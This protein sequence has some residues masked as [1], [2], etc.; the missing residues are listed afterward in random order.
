[1]EA[2][3][4]DIRSWC[5]SKKL[6]LNDKKAKLLHFSSQFRKSTLQPRLPIGDL[7][8]SPSPHAWNLGE[9]MNSSLCMNH[10]NSVCVW[11][12]VRDPPISGYQDHWNTCLKHPGLILSTLC[13]LDSP[14]CPQTLSIIQC[15]SKTKVQVEK[16]HFN[17]WLLHICHRLLY[18][19]IDD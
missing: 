15:V 5:F 10:V 18:N 12:S 19:L 14:M 2:R 9:V 16:R 17:L 4:A 1:M 7:V 13:C 3:I 6:A 11:K 8:I